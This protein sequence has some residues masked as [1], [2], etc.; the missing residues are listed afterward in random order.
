MA[1]GRWSMARLRIGLFSAAW[2]C[3]RYS[4]ATLEVGIERHGPAALRHKGVLVERRALAVRADRRSILL[5]ED[6][7]HADLHLQHLDDAAHA[8]AV[9]G[10]EVRHR[11]RADLVRGRLAVLGVLAAVGLGDQRAIQA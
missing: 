7:A 10:R 6:V 8:P 9:A 4:R 2:F 5:V 11:V 3:R 1:D